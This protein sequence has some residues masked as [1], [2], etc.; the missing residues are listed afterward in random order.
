MCDVLVAMTD[1]TKRGKIIF[2]K[3]SDRPAGE[4]QVLHY[5][6]SRSSSADGRIECSCVNVP[7]DVNVICPHKSVQE[8]HC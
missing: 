6:P 3:N 8:I 2:G 1:A 5:S 7:D 4:F